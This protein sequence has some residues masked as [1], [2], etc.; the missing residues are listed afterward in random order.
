MQDGWMANGHP[1]SRRALKIM[2]GWT[3]NISL[4]P[5]VNVRT[6]KRAK[7]HLRSLR[8][9]NIWSIHQAFPRQIDS[10]EITCS[11]RCKIHMVFKQT[12]LFN[13]FTTLTNSYS[14][15]KIRESQSIWKNPSYFIIIIIIIS[16]HSSSSSSSS[17]SAIIHHISLWDKYI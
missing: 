16:H 3:L 10:W 7:D 5:D 13:E 9:T 11:G 6:T 1:P 17:S 8:Q 14:S 12:K 15:E 2:L 4:Q